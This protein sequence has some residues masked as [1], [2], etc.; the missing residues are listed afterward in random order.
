MIC[1][2]GSP[3]SHTPETVVTPEIVKDLLETVKILAKVGTTSPGFENDTRLPAVA[4]PTKLKLDEV[5]VD[6]PLNLG[7][8]F[9]DPAFAV[10]YC[11]VSAVKVE[12]VPASP[13]RDFTS[14]VPYEV[15]AVATLAFSIPSKKNFSPG[16]KVPL[17]LYAVIIPE[18]FALNLKNA[19]APVAF[20]LMNVG[21]DNVI[22][23]LSEISVYV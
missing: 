15:I 1:V 18:L 5:T 16:A 11:L 14:P 20:P 13:Y 22:G 6:I 8:I 4:T 2:V 21:V 12:A 7:V 17:T 3:P 19:V 23:S 9:T 10:V